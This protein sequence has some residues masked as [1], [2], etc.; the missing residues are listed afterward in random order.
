MITVDNIIDIDDKL[1]CCN[2]SNTTTCEQQLIASYGLDL[3]SIAGQWQAVYN[4]V[5]ERVDGLGCVAKNQLEVVV[6]KA[7]QLDDIIVAEKQA[8]EGVDNGFIVGFSTRWG[9]YSG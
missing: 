7:L 6:K 2:Q 9:G 3:D 4:L 1:Y 8:P 5:F